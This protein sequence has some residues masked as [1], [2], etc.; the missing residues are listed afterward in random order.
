MGQYVEKR[1]TLLLQI[2]DTIDS[3]P[4]PG[5]EVASSRAHN[6]NESPA[7]RA[8][9]PLLMQRPQSSGVGLTAFSFAR[10]LP[11]GKTFCLQPMD[12]SGQSGRKPHET[13]S[14][15]EHTPAEAC[16]NLTQRGHFR[17]ATR[18]KNITHPITIPGDQGNSERH[19]EAPNTERVQ[20][21][22]ASNLQLLSPGNE[23]L[24]TCV[25][26]I[27]GY[28]PQTMGNMLQEFPRSAF[29]RVK[30]KHSIEGS[31][32]A[33]IPTT[34]TSTVIQ[35]PGVL[36]G[37]G[38]RESKK[39]RRTS[40]RKTSST[41]VV[42]ADNDTQ[43]TEEALFQILIGRM[44]EREE[45]ET[46]ALDARE[47]LKGKLSMLI[48]ENQV[49][50]RQLDAMVTRLQKK[51]VESKSY[52]SQIDGWKTRVANFKGLLNE[53]GSEYET[54]R[55]EVVHL[56]TSKESLVGRRRE[57]SIEIMDLRDQVFNTTNTMGELRSGIAKSRDSIHSLQLALKSE[58]EKC[59]SVQVQLSD[60]KKRALALEAYIRVRKL[61]SAFE[62]MSKQLEDSSSS[63]QSVLENVFGECLGSLSHMNEEYTEGKI[64]IQKC[65]EIFQEVATRLQEVTLG[66]STELKTNSETNRS[67][68]TELKSQLQRVEDNLAPGSTL[69]EQLTTT[70]AS[71]TSLGDSL[72]TSMSC[73]EQLDKS[74]KDAQNREYNLM[75]QMGHLQEKLSEVKALPDRAKEDSHA[76]IAKQVELEDRLKLLSTELA[77][78]INNLQTKDDEITHLNVAL[79]EATGRLQEAETRANQSENEVCDL[80]ERVK[81][82]EVD[83]RAELTRAS[84]ISRDQTKA[85]YE[86]QLHELL[87]EKMEACNAMEAMT[88]K[89]QTVEK[90]LV[91]SEESWEKEKNKLE[92][93]D[94]ESRCRENDQKLAEKDAEIERLQDEEVLRSEEK[95]SLLQQ[96]KMANEDVLSLEN[97]LSML[98]TDTSK[99][100]EESQLKLATLQ[101]DIL[102]KEED[103]NKIC[104][105]LTAANLERSN[106]ESGKTKA[107]AEI[108]A[109]LRR[110]QDSEIWLKKIRESMCKSGLMPPE[111][112]F[113]EVWSKLESLLNSSSK[114][115]LKSPEHDNSVTIPNIGGLS[116]CQVPSTPLNISGS[117]GTESVQA[118][119]V[120]YSSQS[121][122]RS[123]QVSPVEGILKVPYLDNASKIDRPPS[124][125]QSVNIVSFSSI[126][127]QLSLDPCS[128]PQ[129]VHSEFTDM[130]LLTPEEKEMGKPTSAEGKA[131]LE[132]RPK[133][134]PTREHVDMVPSTQRTEEGNGD[135][136]TC[137]NPKPDSG[138]LDKPE[139]PACKIK[140]VT[141]ETE[142]PAR[143]NVQEP[144]HGLDSEI[145]QKPSGARKSARMSQ[146]TYSKSGQSSTTNGPE[147][148]VAEN[149]L[150]SA[151]AMNKD[152]EIPS[153]RNQR[154]KAPAASSSLKGKDSTTSD[155]LGRKTSPTRLASGSSKLPSTNEIQT[156]SQLPT[157][158][159]RPTRRRSRSK[160]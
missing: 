22:S 77:N 95:T 3:H 126:R 138:C 85:K 55:S 48:K 54:L 16:G 89:L 25:L 70:K 41:L 32:H 52:R 69:L 61:D 1:D 80:Q 7:K 146:R 122:Q 93:L 125:Q 92:D 8:P 20:S 10:P 65:R 53:V 23:D 101:S 31:E 151:G 137:E 114:A 66:L 38:V 129:D 147:Q 36:E 141:F 121:I 145:F 113:S 42:P 75:E 99:L 17:Q 19:T 149:G 158:R 60:E 159:A 13:D 109:L 28:L 63:T 103:Y 111:Q 136:Q 40:G 81:S 90:S 123:T 116:T 37:N 82:I 29:D 26:I 118:T 132:E 51:I 157:A 47:A 57:I 135:V 67:L 43:M 134:P 12:R 115:Q 62:C 24:E 119:E 156:S 117:P 34:D 72:D 6:A 74:I 154:A 155:C 49:L 94:V 9:S 104:S 100:N 142:D 4:P 140:A 50:R 160:R 56:K 45:K 58:E 108:Y 148:K 120:V 76:T 150:R 127:Q 96:L 86:Q 106:L 97:K 83:V 5:S 139:I 105:E 14:R 27:P 112:S 124:S 98:N 44:K 21:Q 71:C 33:G 30:R 64:G 11:S 79:L 88:K 143:R 91:E 35:E 46:A 87:R 15:K 2:P 84:V 73:V 59:A 153:S 102:K 107:K 78:M 39:R 130:L 144:E 152:T 68:T 131:E 133:I 128:S 110:V 18:S